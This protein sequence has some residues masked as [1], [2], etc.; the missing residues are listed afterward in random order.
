MVTVKKTDRDIFKILNFKIATYLSEITSTCRYYLRFP[1]Y[2]LGLTYTMQLKWVG[3]FHTY[4][5]AKFVENHIQFVLN[6]G[7]WS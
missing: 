4:S 2:I 6:V 7:I 5:Y 3:K 1:L